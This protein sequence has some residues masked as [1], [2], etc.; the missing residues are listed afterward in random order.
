MADRRLLSEKIANQRLLKLVVAGS[1]EVL[2]VIISINMPDR[3]VEIGKDGRP[4]SVVVSSAEEK[5]ADRIF[6]EG[7]EYCEGVLG[8]SVV[9]LRGAQAVSAR[10][11]GR[12]MQKLA[13]SPLVKAIMPS[14]Q[15]G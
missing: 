9:P 1:E 10:A 2:G 5:E 6:K 8:Q 4:T 7:K 3:Q 12:Q 13:A 15:L 14:R 11:N